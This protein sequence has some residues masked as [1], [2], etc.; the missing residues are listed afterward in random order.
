VRLIGYANQMRRR[1]ERLKDFPAGLLF[2][3]DSIC[4]LNP[5]YGQGMT[6]CA[7][8]AAASIAAWNVAAACCPTWRWPATTSRGGVRGR[9]R[10]AARR[11]QRLPVSETRGPRPP[12]APLLGWYITR[13]LRL[14]GAAKWCRCGFL[15]VIHFARPIWSLLMP[16]VLLRV[17]GS[18][19]VPQRAAGNASS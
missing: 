7:L 1:F 16:D 5:L 6:L 2:L 17:L 14:S 19:L 10:L 9:H 3:G 13:L 18:T 12:Y 4:S 8:Q 11:G 15:Q